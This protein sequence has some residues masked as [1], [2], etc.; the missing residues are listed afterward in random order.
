MVPSRLETLILTDATREGFFGSEGSA[1]SMRLLGNVA[2]RRVLV[3]DPLLPK[4]LSDEPEVPRALVRKIDDL[5]HA[6]I[7]DLTALKASS[8][9]ARKIFAE[10][11]LA[12]V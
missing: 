9:A 4:L 1:M 6:T 12:E 10:G 7:R 8:P 5:R 11:D 3:H 2:A